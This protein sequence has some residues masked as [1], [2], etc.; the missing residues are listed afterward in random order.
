MKRL[1]EK[2]DPVRLRKSLVALFLAAAVIG[3]IVQYYRPSSGFP[4]IEQN[5]GLSDEYGLQTGA[6]GRSVQPEEDISSDPR[7]PG[8]ASV[9]LPAE[10]RGETVPQRRVNI[11]RATRAELEELKG[12]GPTKAAAIIAYREAYGSFSCIE[13]ITE[14]KGIGEGTFAKIKDDICTE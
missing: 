12:I 13:E 6:E 4:L 14:V 11:N 5:D 1:I 10:E 2:I 8:A 7:Q 9:I 3:S